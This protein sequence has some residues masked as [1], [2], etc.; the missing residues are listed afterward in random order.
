MKHKEN[1][2]IRGL[3]KQG[4]AALTILGT[5]HAL[6]GQSDGFS[7]AIR[8]ITNPVYFD[9]TLP[10]SNLHPIFMYQQLPGRI[11]TTLGNVNLGGDMQVFAVQAEY[12]FN[13]R[14]SLVAAKDGYI[15]FNP[16]DTAS[17]GRGAL[18]DKSGFAN[19]A[20]GAKWAF[21]YEPEDQF[22]MSLRAIFEFPT[23]NTSVFQ[24]AKYYAAAPSL[25]VLKIWEDFQFTGNVGGIIP[26]NQT[27][28]TELFVSGH[29]SYN[30]RDV[31]FPL[32]E[33]NYF[34][35][36]GAGNGRTR[37]GDQVGGAVPAIATF[38]GGDL[39]NLG[40]ANA[41][42]HR[43]LVTM[44]VGFRVRAIEEVD[45]GFAFEFPLT[46]SSANLMKSRTTIDVIWRY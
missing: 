23:G 31:F 2:T 29:A 21:I 40:A 36:A 11:N 33:F 24:G 4:F 17:N 6:H 28:S 5:A 30:I 15:W 12:A 3:F 7:S 39:I 1:R 19:L 18:S 34:H 35:V 22:A 45:V 14:F 13:E 26:F 43:D 8:P 37:F 41:T 16:D 44:G 32:V 20:G 38:E 27:G 46:R 42:Q 25:S 9:N 10:Q